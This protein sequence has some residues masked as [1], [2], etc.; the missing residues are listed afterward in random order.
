MSEKGANVCVYLK[1]TLKLSIHFLF[2][3]FKIKKK[4]MLLRHNKPDA[5]FLFLRGNVKSTHFLIGNK[6]KNF[7]PKFC[8]F[9][10]SPG[11]SPLIDQQVVGFPHGILAFECLPVQRFP[12][13]NWA[14]D[15]HTHLH[16]Q[17]AWA[18]K[19][20]TV[21]N[22]TGIPCAGCITEDICVCVFVRPL[23]R[24]VCSHDL[25]SIRS[26]FS[27]S[28]PSSRL[29]FTGQHNQTEAGLAQK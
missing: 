14:L 7:H 4:L 20:R 8:I 21:I 11:D 16:I 24:I 26:S 1:G 23:G 29:P 22:R 15:S 6:N 25:P 13:T 2:F 10:C 12:E 17:R 18:H 27:H 19:Y 5:F 3:L 28:F 9:L